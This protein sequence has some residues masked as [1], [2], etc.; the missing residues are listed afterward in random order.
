[1]RKIQAA[2][3]GPCLNIWIDVQFI[4]ARV[5]YIFVERGNYC[6]VPSSARLPT[7]YFL[8]ES[9]ARHRY[10]LATVRYGFHFAPRF[11]NSVGAGRL[12]LRKAI[13]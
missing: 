13:A 7:R 2:P 3:R 4:L 1:M 11:A 10:Q 9:A 8:G 12:R 6:F 5:C